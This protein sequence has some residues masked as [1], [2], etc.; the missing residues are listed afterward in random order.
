MTTVLF[1]KWAED[2]NKIMAKLGRKILILVDNFRG[3]KLTIK[4]SHVRVEFLPPNLT[5][6]LQ[7][8]DAG[9]S[10]VSTPH[11]P[12]VLDTDCSVCVSS[13]SKLIAVCVSRDHPVHQ[14]SL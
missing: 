7:P 8:L 5:S 3:H 10:F 1:Q 6:H 14:S 4:L 2:I 12:L 13:Y 11:S 9:I